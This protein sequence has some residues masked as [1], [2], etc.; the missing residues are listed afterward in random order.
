MTGE[1][2]LRTVLNLYAEHY[3]TGRAHRS[4]GLRAPDDDPNVTPPARCCGQAPPGTWR[5][6][7]RVPHHV[8]PSASPHTGK[9]Q[10]SS[11]NGILTP[12]RTLL[13][14]VMVHVK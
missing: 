1:R 9:A 7:Q 12:F 3:N 8:T 2:H 4:L 6:T 11:L 13:V 10:L 5:T 14:D